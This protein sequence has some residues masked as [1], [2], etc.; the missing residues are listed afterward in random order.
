MGLGT[1]SGNLKEPP[2]G[3][4]QFLEWSDL[5]WTSKFLQMSG[6]V[7]EKTAPTI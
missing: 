7:D 6:H 2:L 1:R 5:T 4:G 3:E